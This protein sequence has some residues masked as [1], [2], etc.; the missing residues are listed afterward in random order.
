[1]TE[2]T[3]K[4]NTH[5]GA[6]AGSGR[7]KTGLMTKSYTIHLPLDVAEE[8]ETRASQLNK[9]VNRYLRDIIEASGQYGNVNLN[10][11]LAASQESKEG[12]YVVDSHN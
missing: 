8:M 6:R 9:T 3:E 4:K 2:I 12:T 1:M 11:K 5:G 7:K 10:D